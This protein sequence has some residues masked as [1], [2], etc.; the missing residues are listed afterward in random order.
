MAYPLNLSVN[1]GAPAG[2]VLASLG[3]KRLKDLARFAEADLAPLHG[4]GPKALQL[5]RGEL[6]RQ[7]LAFRNPKAEVDALMKKARYRHADKVNALRKIILSA[8]RRIVERIKWAG[9]SFYS[10]KVDMG[11]FNLWQKE[12]AQFIF[13][14][15]GKPPQACRPILEGKHPRK[16]EIRFHSMAEIRKKKPLLIKLIRAWI[17]AL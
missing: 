14:F 4:M 7:G 8:D 1:I 2:R 5:L 10:G 17:K 13:L 15:R 12:F 6:K 16:A 3:V 11:A 9:P